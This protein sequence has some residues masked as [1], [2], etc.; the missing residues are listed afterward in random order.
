MRLGSG[1]GG[2]GSGSGIRGDGIR[3]G[4]VGDEG[5]SGGQGCGY[6]FTSL[7]A[8]GCAVLGWDGVREVD[9]TSVR[10][11]V[12]GCSVSTAALRPTQQAAF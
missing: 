11:G 1:G 5:E 12:Q 3:S 10:A 6:I 9:E 8:A 4:D 7:V 2:G